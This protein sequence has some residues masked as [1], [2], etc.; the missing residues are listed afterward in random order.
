[1][2]GHKNALRLLVALLVVGSVIP[3]PAVAQSDNEYSHQ[4]TGGPQGVVVDQSNISGDFTVTVSST[5]VTG[6]SGQKTLLAQKRLGPGTEEK[7][8]FMNEGA[9]DNITV[10]VT[11]H[12]S[13]E[14]EFMAESDVGID[15]PYIIGHTGGDADLQCNKDEKLFSMTNPMVEVVDCTPPV[16][17]GVDTSQTDAE[18]LKIDLYQSGQNAKASSDVYQTTLDNYLQDTET[19]ARIIGKNAYVR[20]LNNGSSKAAAKTEAKN[21]VADYYSTHERNLIAKWNLQ[22]SNYEYNRGVA[23]NESLD[24][25]EE[26]VYQRTAPTYLNGTMGANGDYEQFPYFA[27]VGS[28]SLTLSN[29]TT[30]SA[31]TIVFDEVQRDSTDATHNN[32]GEAG[33]LTMTSGYVDW[34]DSVGDIN[35]VY[36]VTFTGPTSD[37]ED[38][39]AIDLAEYEAKWSEIQSQNTQVQNDMDTV[40]E[41]TYDE[42]QSG[43][44]NNTDLVDPYVLSNDFSAGNEYQS[45]SAAQLTLLGTNSPEAMD[46]MGEFNVTTADGTTHTGVLMSQ[47]NP[48]SGQFEVNTTYDTANITGP[49]FVVTADRLVELDGEFT[50]DSIETTDGESRENVTIEKTTYD[51]ADINVTQLVELYEQLNKERAEWEA[52]EQNLRGG[53]GGFAFGNSTSLGIIAALAG[54]MLLLRNRDDGGRY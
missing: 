27:N 49:Q 47:S 5:E 2:I 31:S 39:E 36:G 51:T 15:V 50:V 23:V 25:N 21:A 37:Y 46:T 11:I 19:Q 53:A 52:R 26:A 45:W 44:I 4:F 32:K 16:D 20:A 8:V 14:P 40:V 17:N 42:Y 10:E 30:V 24:Q 54:G 41:N 1:M 34:E 6:R 48:A 28:N 38:V 18:Q 3:A 13:G 35:T 7:I 43:E 9:Y 12:D 22:V 29:G 33:T